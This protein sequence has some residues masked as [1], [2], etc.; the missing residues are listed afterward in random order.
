MPRI[1]NSIHLSQADARA[2]CD[3][4]GL[5]E[6]TRVSA[7]DIEKM[8]AILRSLG[9]APDAQGFTASRGCSCPRC[10][11]SGQFWH[12]GTC[13]LC[14]GSG[15]QGET[16][17]GSVEIGDLLARAYG[18]P[19]SDDRNAAS[20]QRKQA[21]ALAARNEALAAAGF[22]DLLLEDG[23]LHA[24][25]FEAGVSDIAMRAGA[26]ALTPKQA[27]WLRRAV[28]LLRE[29]R[30]LREAERAAAQPAPEGRVAVRGKVLSIK[31]IE[32]PF[33]QARK[34]L[35]RAETGFRVWLSIPSGAD[36]ERGDAIAFTATLT[37]APDDPTMAFGKRP[38]LAA[39]DAAAAG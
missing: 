11:G 32:S 36:P 30:A 20:R 22:A 38:K 23:S 10:G 17:R 19:T 8:R 9:F 35:V 16:V 39:A 7:L 2:I 26:R 28:D 27:A 21:R 25:V 13:F 12:Y 24:D 37:R 5:T 1:K 4:H 34:M 33:G 14:G 3:A 18:R 29:R 31:T 6:A 15:R